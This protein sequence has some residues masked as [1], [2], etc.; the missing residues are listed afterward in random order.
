VVHPAHGRFLEHLLGLTMST[1]HY[2]GKQALAMGEYVA[3]RAKAKIDKALDDAES[4]DEMIAARA[5]E[6][7]AERKAAMAPIDIM[8]GLQSA[9]EGSARA[10]RD[11]L[12]AGNLNAVGVMTRTLIHMYIEQDSEVMANDWMDRIDAEVAKW[13]VQ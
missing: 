7:I 13:G 1:H 9:N 5:Q 11:Q 3:D 10:L 4:R 8:A 2:C 6:L 12:L